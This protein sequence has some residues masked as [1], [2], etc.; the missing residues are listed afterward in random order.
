MY[1]TIIG[2]P[3]NSPP[4]S[5]WWKC[6][7]FFY[8]FFVSTAPTATLTSATNAGVERN[9]A[10]FVCKVTGTPTPNITWYKD[11]K[12]L[13]DRRHYF[14]VKY[15]ISNGKGELLRFLTLRSSRHQGNYSCRATN[16]IGSSTSKQ[17]FLQVYRRRGG[18]SSGSGF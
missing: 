3:W 9:T 18:K 4:T 16:A 1:E 13:G 8:W 14:Y 15:P 7:R 11:S 5:C 6:Q 2:Y 12:R 17:A 10:Q